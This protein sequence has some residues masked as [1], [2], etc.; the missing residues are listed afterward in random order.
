MFPRSRQVLPRG[1]AQ[2][3]DD[4]ARPDPHERALPGFDFGNA[5]HPGRKCGPS[6]ESRASTRKEFRPS[7]ATVT[8]VIL[9]RISRNGVPGIP[10]SATMP[11]WSDRNVAD[12]ALV[13]VNDQAIGIEW[14]KFEQGFALFHRES[15]A[16]G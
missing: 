15:Q 7:S 2:P 9:V 1:K 10:A 4:G 5:L 16:S 11:C 13:D 8:G 12:I 14:R 3:F 6:S